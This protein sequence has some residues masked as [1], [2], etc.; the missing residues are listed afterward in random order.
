MTPAVVA[1][2][3]A[4]AL[5]PAV[6]PSAGGESSRTLVGNFMSDFQDRVKPL[7][8]VFTP[9]DT[10]RW[11]VVFYFRFNG[12][13]HEYVGTA[14]GGVDRGELSGTV[15]NEGRNRTF[16]FAGEFEDGVFKGR[17]AELRGGGERDTG[18]LTLKGQKQRG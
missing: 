18:T 14:E 8:A 10:D 11:D 5:T 1:L 13:D 16:T 12:R 15:Q 4:L 7:R 9:T 2:I 6:E 17:H 3:A